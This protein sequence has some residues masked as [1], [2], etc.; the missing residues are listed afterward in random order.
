M[1]HN[2]NYIYNYRMVKFF[3]KG[4]K[5]SPKTTKKPTDFK[6]IVYQ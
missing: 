5:G 2:Y 3:M 6:I 1:N 4:F